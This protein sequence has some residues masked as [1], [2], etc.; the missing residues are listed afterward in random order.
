MKYVLGFLF[1]LDDDS[2]LLVRKNRPDWQAGLLNGIGGKI[3]SGENPF[4]AMTREFVEETGIV[5][6]IKWFNFLTS[7]VSNNKHTEPAKLYCFK[8]FVGKTPNFKEVNDVGESVAKFN[9]RAVTDRTDI[10]VNLN[11]MIPLAWYEPI[12]S[13]AKFRDSINL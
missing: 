10:M 8:A 6:D 1:D 9:R 5:Q 3:E 13:K 4:D 2:I 12:T 7:K 11:W